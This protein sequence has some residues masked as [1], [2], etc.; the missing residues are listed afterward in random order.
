M[1]NQILIE[2]QLLSTLEFSAALEKI[3]TQK[4]TAL[5]QPCPTALVLKTC[6]AFADYITRE[7]NWLNNFSTIDGIN[8]CDLDSLKKEL[9]HFCQHEY[10][11]QKLLREFKTTSPLT[12]RRPK[13]KENIF[14]SW[15]PLGCV[16]HI[17]PS[18]AISLPFMAIIE[19]LL[20][21]NFNILRPSHRDSGLSA[22]LLHQ[23]ISLDTSGELAKYIVVVNTPKTQLS[24]IMKLADG[25]SA[26]GG[27]N[28]LNALRAQIP[29]GCR[30][31]EW[32]H[33]L[34]FA[35]L[36]PVGVG[37]Q[38]Y[39]AI[40]KDVCQ[41]DQQACS[42]P[43]ILL[44]NT[45]NW[46]QLLE[47]GL[48]MSQAMNHISDWY[49][50]LE[51]S[52]QEA[53]EITTQVHLA[54]LEY[55]LGSQKI[56]IWEGPKQNWRIILSDKPGISPSPLFRTLL[57]SPAPAEALV[58]LLLPFRPWLQTSALIAKATAYPSLAQKLLA[59]GVTRITAAGAMHQEY[60]GE[61]HDGVYALPQLARRVSINPQE[62]WENS[63]ASINAPRFE[64]DE[65]S[66]QKSI[67]QKVDFIAQGH[68][69]SHAQIYFQSGGTSGKP[70]L[71]AFSYADYHLQMQTAADGIL[72]AGLDPNKDCVM[73]LLYAGNL[74]GGFHCYSTVLDKLEVRQLPMAGPS[75][76]DLP[77]VARIIIDQ[78]VNT[79]I[80]MPTTLFLLFSQQKE[81]LSQYRGIKKIFYGGEFMGPGQR[82][83][84]EE[85]GVELI[86]S[87]MYGSVDA[88]ILGYACSHTAEGTFHLIT[89]TQSLEILELEADIPVKG[90]QVGR[91]I[92]S[93]NRE[94][95]PLSRYE[96][97]DIGRWVTSP[98]SCGSTE[99]TFELLGRIGDIIKI[100]T[101]LIDCNKIKTWIE[102]HAAY[103]G[104]L[105]IRLDYNLT[106][107]ERM[108]L[109]FNETPALSMSALKQGLIEHYKE[110]LEG[111]NDELLVIDFEYNTPLTQNQ[112]SGKF[113]LIID[114]RL[115]LA[116]NSV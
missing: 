104:I 1:R 109:C 69:Q 50:N 22:L 76:A 82:V 20:A 66:K 65:I 48:R 102:Q 99:P 103:Q 59:A 49:P 30:F 95:Q 43:Q 101:Y 46:D 44:V 27:D 8:T 94:A 25:V 68:N 114:Q 108:T 3:K 86:R 83:L 75:I 47:V 6:Q 79:L 71:A 58:T 14:E 110:L 89:E 88:G 105:Q 39:D 78:G 60:A 18:N 61:P 10:L 17:T 72:A 53:A 91:L 12:I 15:Q 55:A 106:D 40:A 54:Q 62:A 33:K 97:G 93:S 80:G 51:P 31:I 77:F 112:H 42:S 115:T 70:K 85:M 7:P 100:G 67:M 90:N 113:P 37:D 35:Y 45:T 9:S 19:G 2:G 81:L 57:I 92:F 36:N 87:A 41:F 84:Y 32:G 23:L 28:A 11:N 34:S 116:A 73:N 52:P 107:K 16:V 24:D 98:C 56:K 111:I 21:G 29:N 64:P 5:I 26:W 63:R 4:N 38:C 74:Y 96:I 13:L